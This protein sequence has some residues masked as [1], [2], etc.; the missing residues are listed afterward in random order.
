LKI[1][2]KYRHKLCKKVKISSKIGFKQKT[3]ALKIF[4]FKHYITDAPV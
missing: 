2:Q 3:R 4:N 1:Y